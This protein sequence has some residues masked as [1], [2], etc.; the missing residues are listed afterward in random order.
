M[1]VQK[2]RKI[3][4]TRQPLTGGM[5]SMSTINL[6]RRHQQKHHYSKP[7]KEVVPMKR[8]LFN[9]GLMYAIVSLFVM[10]TLPVMRALA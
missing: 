4:R 10:L 2:S 5:P 9:Q 1:Q 7:R 3:N 8:E 6:Q